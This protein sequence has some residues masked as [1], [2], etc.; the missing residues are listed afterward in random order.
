MNKTTTLTEG[1]M[2]D[3]GEN[4][5]SSLPEDWTI[6]VRNENG[7]EM[8]MPLRDHPSLAKYPSKDDAVKAL[9]HAQRLIGRR[10]EGV[11]EPPGP[12]ASEEERAAFYAALGRPESP[13]EYQ[14]PELETPEGFEFDEDM[15]AQFRQKA[16]EL[17]LSP[18]QV[19]GLY[20]CQS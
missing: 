11:I 20:E 15:Q 18:G 9:V 17:G 4:W 2:R 5:R 14:L 3:T 19:Q 1:Q 10:P 7:E 16:H 8:E 12:E 6:V 13:D